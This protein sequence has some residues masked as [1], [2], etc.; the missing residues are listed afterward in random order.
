MSTEKM[1]FTA[2]HCHSKEIK[3]IKFTCFPDTD[4]LNCALIIVKIW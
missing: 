4:F 3:F 1:V 2:K